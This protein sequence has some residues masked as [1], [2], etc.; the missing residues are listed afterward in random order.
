MVAYARER[1][2]KARHD[3]LE[4]AMALRD[5]AC[6]N[7]EDRELTY[8]R[9]WWIVAVRS[10]V[11]VM[12]GRAQPAV[13]AK[14]LTPEVPE[15][16]VAKAI[17]L[18]LELGLLKKAS[19]GRFVLAETHLNAGG[20]EKKIAVREFQRQ[21]LSLASDSLERFPKEKRDVSTLT[22]AVDQSAFS[23]IREMLREFRQQIQK[24]VEE[25]RHPDRVMQLSMAFFPIASNEGDHE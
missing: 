23:E 25:A 7:L 17:E 6:R 16:E 15:V 21:V 12:E 9:S 11:E 13:L 3:I 1:N 4:K 19:S 22:L 2:P 8:F 24:R 14:K 10:L 5:V 18:L 20:D